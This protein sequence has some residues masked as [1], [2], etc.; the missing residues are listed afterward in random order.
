MIQIRH[1]AYKPKGCE[2]YKV[3]YFRAGKYWFQE[4]TVHTDEEIAN[5]L[6]VRRVVELELKEHAKKFGAV[7]LSKKPLAEIGAEFIRHGRRKGGRRNNPWSETY[8]H[9]V[10]VMFAWWLKATGWKV[11]EDINLAEAEEL[12]DAKVDERKKVPASGSHKNNC[13][14]VLMGIIK[15]AKKSLNSERE[16]LAPKTWDP[17]EDWAPY[18]SDPDK[19]FRDF[20]L[21]EFQALLQHTPT[22]E[23][24]VAYLV[25]AATDARFS[26]LQGLKVFD[27]DFPGAQVRI[28]RRATG[29]KAKKETW[30]KIPRWVM[31]HVEDQARGRSPG[32]VLLLGLVGHHAGKTVQQ[33]LRAAGVPVR[34]AKGVLSF[35][36]LKVTGVN[37]LLDLGTD[38]RTVQALAD[39]STAE[40][41]AKVYG[42]SRERLERQ[43]TE[44]VG[45]WLK[46]AFPTSNDGV[47][48][49][50]LL[51]DEPMKS[52]GSVVGAAGFEP[53]STRGDNIGKPGHHQAS[54]IPFK[55]GSPHA[56]SASVGPFEPP[57]ESHTR[58]ML[59]VQLGDLVDRLGLDGVQSVVNHARG[60]VA[61]LLPNKDR[62][63]A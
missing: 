46:K 15:F 4:N 22:M 39:H 2:T 16:P 28:V 40:L 37:V 41:S 7:E 8:A 50:E 53:V 27:A 20:E 33:R 54:L 62:R 61:G 9:D 52:G 25:A 18:N 3:K 44:G 47:T 38:I 23:E 63:T 17:L 35:H 56:G 43:A 59:Y 26:A 45:D 30:K 51:M 31:D 29:N 12:L 5:R 60:W 24:R 58:H 49:K 55:K 21:S 42:R 1:Y 14:S 36:S 13:M 34:T 57:A 10:E 48:R 19:L 32:D 6:G 11:L